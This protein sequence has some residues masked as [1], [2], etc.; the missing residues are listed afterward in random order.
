MELT[1]IS[2]ALIAIS[3]FCLLACLFEH[4]YNKKIK[5]R[6]AKKRLENKSRLNRQ[7][8]FAECLLPIED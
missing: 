4:C 1:F 8:T 3:I 6:Q 5:T 7:N 2:L